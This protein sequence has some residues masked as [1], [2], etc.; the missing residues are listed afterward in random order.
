[1]PT[2]TSKKLND[3]KT[4]CH[5][6]RANTLRLN[7]Q[8]TGF[9]LFQSRQSKVD[10]VI[11][12]KLDGKILTANCKSNISEYH[13]TNNQSNIETQTKITF[14]ENREHSDEDLYTNCANNLSLWSLCKIVYLCT[15]WRVR[16]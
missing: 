9:V 6:L 8:K 7:L 11:K 13:L 4:L 1:M 3:L 5:W 10:N 2:N 14:L 16:N 15:S 12:V